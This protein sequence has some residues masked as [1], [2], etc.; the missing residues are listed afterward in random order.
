MPSRENRRCYRTSHEENCGENK[1]RRPT[2]DV[3]ILTP[4]S[5][6]ARPSSRSRESC[7]RSGPGRGSESASQ[8]RFPS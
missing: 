3:G 6:P 8:A 5:K 2:V 4:A 7:Y 1:E